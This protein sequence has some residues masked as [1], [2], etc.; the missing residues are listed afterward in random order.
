MS[1]AGPDLDAL[2]RSDAPA[3]RALAG[4][5]GDAV[6]LALETLLLDADPDPGLWALR[7][8]GALAAVLPE[9]AA[10]ADLAPE[11]GHPHKDLWE[12][13]LAVVARCPPRPVLR[14][15]ALLHDIGKVS[16][17]QLL[18]DGR[19]TFHGHAE[20]GAGM[21]REAVAPRLVF[22][23]ATARAI[24]QLVLLHQ[25]PGTYVATWQDSA[26]RRLARDVGGHLEDLLDLGRAD[27][28]SRRAGRQEEAEIRIAA[29]E[30]RIA[31]IR[32]VDAQSPV[33]PP[34][35]GDRLIS[36][37]GMAA[38]PEIGALRRRLAAA[39]EAGALQAGQPAEY[40]VTALRE[41]RV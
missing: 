13:T 22:P 10:L 7:T 35:L 28:T 21:V 3:W 11:P 5:S 4:A 34:G 20:V 2:A 17:R 9:V 40:Y 33:L 41:K 15:A 8:S 26:V 38:G 18:P 19:V 23:E 32:A 36:D 16:A 12:H 1:A 6:R 30:A 39:V 37:L 31:A 29:L 25:R 24:G 14:W 27:V